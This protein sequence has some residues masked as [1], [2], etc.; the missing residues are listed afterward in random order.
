MNQVPGVEESVAE[1]D[2]LKLGS[3]KSH[4]FE[5]RIALRTGGDGGRGAVGEAFAFVGQTFAGCI[6][7]SGG[8]HQ[9][10][11]HARSLRRCKQVLIAFQP[12][13]SVAFSRSFHVGGRV[14]FRQ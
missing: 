2:A 10:A 13:A 4:G 1:G 3:T 8:L 12:H 11:T 5:L 14:M 7:E 6:P 9:E